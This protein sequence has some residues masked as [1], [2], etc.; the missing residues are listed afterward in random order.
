MKKDNI[1]LKTYFETGDYPTES[2]F[3]D[4]IDSFLNIEEEDA[5][6]GITNNGDGTYTFQLLS[7]GIEILDVES[8][9]NNIPISTIVG[10]QAILDALPLQYLRKDQDDSTTGSIGIDMGAF[11]DGKSFYVGAPGSTAYFS[12]DSNGWSIFGNTSANDGQDSHIV[13]KRNGGLEFNDRGTVHTILHTGNNDLFFTGIDNNNKTLE[14]SAPSLNSGDPILLVKSV[15]ESQ[16]WRVEHSGKCSTTNPEIHVNT[17]SDG[18]GGQKVWHEGNDGSGSGLDADLLDGVDGSTYARLDQD[19][20]FQGRVEMNVLG[21]NT[22]GVGNANSFLSFMNASDTIATF[23]NSTGS[24]NY[25]TGFGQSLMVRGA[26]NNR[27]F[28]LYKP[29]GNNSDFYLGNYNDSASDWQWNRVWHDG[30]DGAGS[31]LNADNLDN[32]T[33]NNVTGFDISTNND[34]VSG[35]GSGGVAMTINDGYGNANLTFNHQNGT[36]EQNGNAA[37]IEVNTDA[38]SGAYFSFEL[39]SNVSDGVAVGLSQSLLLKEDGAVFNDDVTADNFILSSDARL[40]T[41]VNDIETVPISVRWREFELKKKLGKK[42]FGVIAQELEERHPEFVER[43]VDGK[44]SVQ[45]IDLL[46]AKM[47]EKDRQLKIMEDRLKKIEA[48]LNVEV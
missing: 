1:T 10:L 6:T 37:R 14:F 38:S 32:Y 23:A 44:L 39:K 45:Y 25:P 17:A 34:V 8:L 30:N 46:V 35:R 9:P 19:E 41:K 4:L 31:G 7:G 47:A 40:K 15:G 13:V 48:L 28:T 20:V 42:R 21:F 24:T 2:Q 22:G 33:W 29:N 26:T 11:A 36:P 27:S 43:D 16:R 12:M 3:A 5:V 18:S